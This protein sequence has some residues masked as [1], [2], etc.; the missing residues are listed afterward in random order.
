MQRGVLEADIFAANNSVSRL[1]ATNDVVHFTD[2]SFVVVNKD[3][4]FDI[5]W[6]LSIWN[7]EKNAYDSI[8]FPPGCQ[9][10]RRQPKGWGEKRN[11]AA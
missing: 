3:G 1:A 7:A 5:G 2:G 6:C 8:P 10:E 11:G 4:K 9:S